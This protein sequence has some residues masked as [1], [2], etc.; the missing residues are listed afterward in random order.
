[1]NACSLATV[2]TLAWLTASL[3]MTAGILAVVIVNESAGPN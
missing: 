2:L 1:M 3:L